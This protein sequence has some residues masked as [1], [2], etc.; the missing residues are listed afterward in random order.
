M[1]ISQ[2]CHA[3]KGLVNVMF[4]NT[5]TILLLTYMQTVVYSSLQDVCIAQTGVFYQYIYLLQ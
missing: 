2:I 5:G 3:F 1:Q 4:R